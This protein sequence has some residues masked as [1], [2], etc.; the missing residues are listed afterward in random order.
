MQGFINVDESTYLPINGFTT[1]D[2]GCERGNNAYSF[3]IRQEA[4]ENGRRFLNLFEQ[5]WNDTKKMQDVTDLILESISTAYKENS[6]DFIYFFTLYNI[7]NSH[8][9]ELR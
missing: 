6:P 9:V 5:V 4:Y 3:V 1:V 8:R 7:F 2:L